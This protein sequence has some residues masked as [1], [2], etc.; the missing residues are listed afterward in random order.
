MAA[1]TR[2]AHLEFGLAPRPGHRPQP[3]PRV[4]ALHRLDG[5][6]RP[7]SPMKQPTGFPRHRPRWRCQ[8]SGHLLGAARVAAG[9]DS[10]E[11]TPSGQIY[12]PRGRRGCCCRR[13]RGRHRN[14]NRAARPSPRCTAGAARV[15]QGQKTTR[16]G[17]TG[18]GAIG[19][20]CGSGL[21]ILSW[22]GMSLLVGRARERSGARHRHAF[23]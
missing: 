14:R 11:S 3:R 15:G 2:A 18:G 5:A 13:R 22:R 19:R 12:S 9:R 4:N 21:R 17:Q 8:G 23:F 6:Q 7:A 16:P 1:A 10:V 20:R